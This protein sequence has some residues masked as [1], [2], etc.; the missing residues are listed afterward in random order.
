L[1]SWRRSSPS[2]LPQVRDITEIIQHAQLVLGLT[3][4]DLAKVF[5][6][7]RQTLY[8]RL[9]EGDTSTPHN[10]SRFHA[11]DKIVTEIEAATTVAFGAS[12][13][14]LNVGGVT[15]FD[16]LCAEEPD[17]AQIVQIAQIIDTELRRR[18]EELVHVSDKMLKD[19][20]TRH[21]PS[22]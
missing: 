7:S 13:K 14:T 8:S 16:A 20:L 5:G 18:S 10:A 15:L 9:K 19:N 11:I 2:T 12:A 17:S 1:L 3:I 4:T 21:S 22:A 6:V